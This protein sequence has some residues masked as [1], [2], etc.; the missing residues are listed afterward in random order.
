LDPVS[1]ELIRRLAAAWNER[2][3][4]RLLALAHPE[5]EYVNSPLAVEPG[6]RHGHEGFALVVTKQW[7]A[8]GPTGRQDVERC[9]PAG[10][11]VI[12]S[13][14]VSR[15]MPNSDIRVENRVAVRFSFQDGL[16]SRLEVLPN[17]PS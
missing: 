15:T 7:E 13:L 16:V 8:F 14:L 11:D 12:A 17:P 3:L 1:L 9:T 5:L 10:D 2:D 4:E 6:T